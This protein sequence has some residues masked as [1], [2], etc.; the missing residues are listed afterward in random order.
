MDQSIHSEDFSFKISK[1]GTPKA[2]NERPTL[3]VAPLPSAGVFEQQVR[4]DLRFPDTD[5]SS[6]RL[7]RP[8]RSTLQNVRRTT[9]R[10]YP[11][12]P[13]LRITGSYFSRQAQMLLPEEHWSEVFD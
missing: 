11:E 10:R 1:G 3:A 8:V 7:P 2:I 5:D 12:L 9:S 6:R 13:I 4:Y